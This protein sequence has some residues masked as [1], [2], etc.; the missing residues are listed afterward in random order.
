MRSVDRLSAYEAIKQLA[1]RWSQRLARPRL[2]R[3]RRRRHRRCSWSGACPERIEGGR[4]CS[5][6]GSSGRTEPAPMVVTDSPYSRAAPLFPSCS[7]LNSCPRTKT[8]SDGPLC[9]RLH[10]IRIVHRSKALDPKSSSLLA[11]LPAA[12][13]SFTPYATCGAFLFNRFGSFYQQHSDI[14]EK[15]ENRNGCKKT[16]FQERI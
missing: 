16:S 6:P 10:S 14:K 1:S 9:S 7:A 12:A 5:V 4:C 8:C 3:I 13:S 11:L 15:Q 2:S